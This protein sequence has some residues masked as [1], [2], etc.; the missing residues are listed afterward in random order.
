MRFWVTLRNLALIND[1]RWIYGGLHFYPDCPNLRRFPVK[2]AEVH[3][4]YKD[5]QDHWRSR[6]MVNGKRIGYM[7]QLCHNRRSQ[8]AA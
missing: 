1:D 5:H 2:T 4:V 6:V 8:M 3:G 7:C